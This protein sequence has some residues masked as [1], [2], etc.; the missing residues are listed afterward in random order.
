MSRHIEPVNPPAGDLPAQFRQVCE[1]WKMVL[2][3]AGAGPSVP[4]TANTSASTSP[5]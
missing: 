5:P 3:A 4:C 2:T 1:N